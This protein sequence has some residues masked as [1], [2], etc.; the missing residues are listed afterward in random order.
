VSEEL[1]VL[2]ALGEELER[3]ASRSPATSRRGL[4]VLGRLSVAALLI[5]VVGIAAV[6]TAAVLLIREGSSLPPAH[7]QDLRAGGIPL[8]GTA[9]LAGLDAPDPSAGSPPWDL[10]LSRTRE[11]EIC[12]AVGQVLGGRF[13][14]VGLDHVF[15]ALPLGSVDVCS[16]DSPRGTVLAGAREFVGRAAAEARTVVS[17]VAGT[18]AR[19]VTAYGPTGPR[20]LRLGPDGS[21][22]TVYQGEPEQ[23]R[24]Q[25]VVVSRGGRSQRIAFEQSSANEVPDPGRGAPWVVSTEADLQGSAGLDEDCAQASQNPT[26]AQPNLG[27]R[28]MTP[29]VCGHLSSQPLFVLMRRFV[30]E[31]GRG[32]PFPWGNAPART[33]VYGIADP[34]VT[35][36]S[37]EGAGSTRRLPIDRHGGSFLAVLDGH[38]DPASLTL[39]ASLDDGTTRKYKGSFGVLSSLSNAPLGVG[40]APAYRAPS[41]T[42]ESFPPF[43]IPIASSVR[44]TLQAKDPV[45]G[46]TWVVRSWKGAPNTAVSGVK[47]SQGDFICMALGVRENGRLVEPSSDPSVAAA[48][49]GPEQGRCNQVKDLLRMH[50]MLSWESF[51]NDPFAYAPRPA[52]TVLSGVLPPGASEA[53]LFGAGQPRRLTLDGNGAFLLVL[54]GRYWTASPHIVYRLRGKLVGNPHSTVRFPLGSA[55]EKPQSRAPDPDGA[56]PWG[57]AA[58]RTCGT[59]IGRIVEGR[60]ASL[61]ERTG[62]LSTGAEITGGSSACITRPSML[63]RIRRGELV[64][65]DTQQAESYATPFSTGPPAL[66]LPDIERRTPPGRTIITG[67]ALPQVSSITLSTPS[68]VRTLRPSGPLHTIIAVYDGYFLRGEITARISLTSGQIRTETITSG[69]ARMLVSNPQ[70]PSLAVRLSSAEQ[71]LAEIRHPRLSVRGHPRPVDLQ[72]V[73]AIQSDIDVIRRRIAYERMRPGLLPAE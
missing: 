19:Q 38:V 10:R 43:Q 29:E 36:L 70:P 30:P 16:A 53:T 32:G 11:G 25:I 42:G 67:V 50:Y 49:V 40:P 33:L 9:R 65:F 20:Q 46:P 44:E 14:I 3:A 5:G 47:A 73:R 66:T 41:P 26:Q 37:L 4:D 34:R 72:L 58:T 22:I 55:P 48:P 7:T 2:S 54:P 52:R 13:G 24:P 6:A 61:D 64:E 28:P 12:T 8:P 18:D 68:D 31:S 15:R 27:M 35:S 60:F 56:A 57:F 59:A 63:P 69:P 51:L 1:R 39:T 17:G 71:Q 23:V 45:G 21:F 62:V